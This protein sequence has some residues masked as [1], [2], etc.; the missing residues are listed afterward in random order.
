MIF[1]V[2]YHANY[3]GIPIGGAEIRE[4]DTFENYLFSE[5]SIMRIWSD[6]RFRLFTRKS[7]KNELVGKI[8]K[9]IRKNS[10]NGAFKDLFIRLL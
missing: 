9:T 7:P 8:R 5:N 1:D 6:K 10:Q 3:P 4:I 2:F